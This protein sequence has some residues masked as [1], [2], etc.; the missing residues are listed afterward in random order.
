MCHLIHLIEA[1]DMGTVTTD[2]W[3]SWGQTKAC[4]NG[5]QGPKCHTLDGATAAKILPSLCAYG[6]GT[7]LL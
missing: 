2:Q 7:Q 4:L 1:C 3:W 5:T 6:Q